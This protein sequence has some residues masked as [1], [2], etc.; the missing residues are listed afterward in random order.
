M[1][2][3]PI[4]VFDEWPEPTRSWSITV[5]S[6]KPLSDKLSEKDILKKIPIGRCILIAHRTRLISK[7]ADTT[8]NNWAKERPDLH[9]IVITAVARA[10]TSANDRIYFRRT[11]VSEGADYA[12]AER[13]ERFRRA[14]EAGKLNFALL[15]PDEL[16]QNLLCAYLVTLAASS[17]K[18]RQD[19]DRVSLI[20]KVMSNEAWRAAQQEFQTRL[21]LTNTKVSKAICSGTWPESLFTNGLPIEGALTALKSALSSDHQSPRQQSEA[22][23]D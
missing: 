22:N 15:E 21:R 13:F 8:L 2:A 23:H 11:P 5:P 6:A 1:S 9:I 14:F 4:L 10:D 17:A 7:G 16:P 20:H 3:T 19:D 18:H 12:F